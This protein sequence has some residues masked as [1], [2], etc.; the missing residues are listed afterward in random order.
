M[1]MAAAIESRTAEAA[2]AK[3]DRI[4]DVEIVGD[5][6]EA[7]AVWRTLESPAHFSTGYQR[8]DFLKAWQTQA[9]QRDSASIR[10]PTA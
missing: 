6:G 8:F 9:G 2:R 5:L 10:P 4:A 3:P 1:T 7:E